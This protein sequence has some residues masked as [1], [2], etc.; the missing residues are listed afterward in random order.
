M[1]P[2]LARL[3]LEGTLG[4]DEALERFVDWVAE[5]GLA[6][7]PAQE[8]AMLELASGKHV[9]LSTPTGS[10]KSLVALF[11]HFRALAEGARSFYTAP[12]KALVSEKFFALCDLFGAEAVGMLTG[13]ASINP[14]ADVLCCTQEVLASM[15]LRSGEALDAPYAVLDEFH[16]YSDRERGAAW[17][18]PLLGLPRTTFLLLS[19][20][21]GNMAPIAERME[22]RSGRAVA[23]VH[24]DLRPVPLEF[25]WRETP[26]HE[27]VE[28]L[29]EEG[30]APIY[31]VNFTQRECGEEAQA[32]TSARIADREL[33]ER[34][35]KALGG[36]RFDTSYGAELGRFVRA[37]IGVHHAGLLP[38]YRLLVEKLAQQGLLRV[39]CGTDTL[40]VGV[41]IPIRTVLF[42]K[43][44]KFDGERV[45]I[46]SAREFKQIAGRAGRRGFDERGWVVCQAPEHVIEKRRA[47]AKFAEGRRPKV[48]RKKAP[49]GFVG[50]TRETFEQL[51]RRLPEPLESRFGVDHGMLLALLQRDPA[52]AATSG[53]RAVAEL[54]D[55]SHE[56]ARRKRRLLREAARVFRSLRRAGILVL[57]RAP[58]GAGRH[59]RVHADLQ[60][61]FSLY[62][63]LSLYLVDAVAAL[64][65]TD[66]HHALEVLT[67]VEAILEDPRAILFAQVDRARGE[68]IARLKAE[69][70]DYEDRIRR[71][72]EVT[73]PRPS[74]EFLHATYE[75]FVERH[76]WLAEQ[77]IRPKSIAREMVERYLDFGAYV[78]ELGIARSEGLLLRYLSDVHNTLA[79]NVPESAKTAE[80]YDVL[81][82]LR[83]LVA[84]VD[85]SLLE[86]WERLLAPGAPEREG[87]PAPPGVPA[88][89]PFDLAEHPKALH[90]RIRAELHALVRALAARDFAD[91]AAC[92]R[93]DPDD[94]WPAARFE[95]AL[96]PYF[97]EYGEIVFTPAARA[98]HRTLVRPAGARVWDATQVIVDPRGDEQWCVRARVELERGPIPEGP[99]V[100]VL[101]IGI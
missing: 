47:E 92:V 55:Y 23:H 7:Y 61:E 56:D 66:P 41:N 58:T 101:E 77:A 60:R 27:T 87:E 93:H 28:A 49:P 17:Q 29:L 86:A 16:Y 75:I 8:E 5:T 22:K 79:R 85:S 9:I 95:Q 25:S 98:L 88:P 96:A 30:R 81:A 37:G 71:L 24:S 99:L 35:G 2:L 26:L 51:Q 32:L 44:A 89:R 91:A 52:G 74:A 100:R 34:I 3:P 67:L 42:T 10:G 19:A 62:H 82:Y 53:Y 14:E 21:L 40:G 54:I 70:V 33:R 45:A 59:V 39:I 13:D 90:A 76:P 64:E 80:V 57:E 94:A 18:I 72:D 1:P 46:L 65:P 69:G 43:L 4:A 20:T 6:P 12:T 36:F 84:R 11:L 73:W 63:T 38:R 15:A 50:W 97:A 68:L 31:V 83:A 48:G 78:R